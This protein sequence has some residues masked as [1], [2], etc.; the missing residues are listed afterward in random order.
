MWHRNIVRKLRIKIA[1]AELMSQLNVNHIS[2]HWWF[3]IVY[4]DE[5]ILTASYYNMIDILKLDI[6]WPKFQNYLLFLPF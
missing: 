1:F 6:F 4:L 2:F 5:A 3:N